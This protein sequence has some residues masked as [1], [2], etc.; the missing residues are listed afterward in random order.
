MSILL[1]KF[2]YEWWK[3]Y[4]K[5]ELKLADFYIRCNYN[6]FIMFS[7]S[8]LLWPNMGAPSSFIWTYDFVTIVVLGLGSKFGGIQIKIGQ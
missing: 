6:G 8:I 1:V 5:Y 4:E 3:A 2:P 7:T